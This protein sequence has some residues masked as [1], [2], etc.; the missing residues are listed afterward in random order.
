[1]K[2][3]FPV[4]E[5]G[6]LVIDWSFITS[7]ENSPQPERRKATGKNGEGESSEEAPPPKPFVFDKTTFEDAVV[8]PS[9]RYIGTCNSI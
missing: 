5:S 7:V 9:Y 8:M 6:E 1:M 4:P 3:L 2:G